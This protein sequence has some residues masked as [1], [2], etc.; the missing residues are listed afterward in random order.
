[1]IGRQ[2]DEE[3][4]HRGLDGE[5]ERDHLIR[6]D[7]V[8]EH[9]GGGDEQF[10]QEGLLGS[11]G[12]KDTGNPFDLIGLAGAWQRVTDRVDP[13]VVLLGEQDGLAGAEVAQHVGFGEADLSGDLVE[14]DVGDR[15]ATVLPVSIC[16]G[17]GENLVAALV[18]L[19]IGSSHRSA[20][21][22]PG[23][24]LRQT[25]QPGTR[26]GRRGL[27]LSGIATTARRSACREHR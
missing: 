5:L 4:L 13:C 9:R 3:P 12:G 19:L 24:P 11:G 20:R 8:F 22:G 21:R 27:R 1:M 16:P 18:A 17:G 7:V 25:P 26:E 14:A 10:A 15:S 6:G 2:S 23:D